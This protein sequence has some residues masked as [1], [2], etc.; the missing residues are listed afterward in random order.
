[1]RSIGD[2]AGDSGPSVSALRFYDR[3]GVLVPAWVDPVSGY[4]WYAPEQLEEARL[5]ARLRRAG[6]PLADIRLVLAGWSA[7]D[8]DLV[9]EL[10]KAHLH[11]LGQRLSDAR[12]EFS[13]LRALLDHREN[14][15]T[16]LRIA[17]VRLSVAAPELAA[18]LDTVRFAVGTDLELPMLGG[19]FDIEGGNLRTVATDRYRMAVA[20][21]GTTGHD[22]G[23][24]QVVVPTPLVDAMRVLLGGEGTARLAVDGDRVTLEVGDRQATGR[25]LDHDFPGYRRLLPAADGRRALVEV[26]DFREALE[27]GPVRSGEAGAHDLGVLRVEDDGT[28]ALCSDSDSPGVGTSHRVGVNRAFLLDAL[29]ALAA[30]TWDRLVLEV[31]APTA[32]IAIRRPDDEGAF[33]VLMPVRL[34]D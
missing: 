6:M 10:L 32:P 17:S 34:E 22:E 3:A 31:S 1:M 14:A 28:V 18:A 9:R 15:M 33:S 16:S 23:R 20:R 21:A 29:A 12:G 26:A 11:R 5:L 27:T 13:A 2:M 24:V 4:R 25:C 7:A 19:V 8:G 30:G